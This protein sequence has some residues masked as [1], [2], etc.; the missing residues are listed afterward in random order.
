MEGV[1]IRKMVTAIAIDRQIADN[2]FAESSK[3][4]RGQLS[5]SSRRIFPTLPLQVPKA[6]PSR[7]SGIGGPNLSA[8]PSC[9]NPNTL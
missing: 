8:W 4:D 6:D 1:D 3:S 5:A 7:A 2:A 9:F